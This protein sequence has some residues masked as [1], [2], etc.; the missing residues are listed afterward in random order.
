MRHTGSKRQRGFTLM[1]LMVVVGVIMVAASVAIAN[2]PRL[3]LDRRISRAAHIL[4]GTIRE[5]RGRAIANRAYVQVVVSVGRI[6]LQQQKC[7][8]GNT[9]YAWGDVVCTQVDLRR[10]RIG[11]M[12]GDFSKVGNSI[13]GSG[14]TILF[15][16]WGEALAVDVGNYAFFSRDDSST[17]TA[18]GV[19]VNAQGMAEV[20]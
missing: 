11:D 6:Q 18:L 7:P 16:P 2:M 5:A 13:P 19:L 9:V 8:F 10:Y 3:K 15:S 20:R 14:G 12:S 1:E 4:A 17:A